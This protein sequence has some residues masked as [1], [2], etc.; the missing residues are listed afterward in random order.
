ML[1]KKHKL[2]VIDDN[3]AL[4]ERRK[5][6]A[7]ASDYAVAVRLHLVE[8]GSFRTLSE[9]SRKDGLSGQRDK[10]SL[11]LSLIRQAQLPKGMIVA[12]GSS[13]G[14]CQNFLEQLSAL[15]LHFVVALTTATK[16]KTQNRRTNT[17]S[18]NA[19]TVEDRLTR[20]R[21]RKIEVQPPDR[22]G[23]SCYEASE[24]GF[25]QLGSLE[26]LRLFTAASGGVIGLK[27]GLFIGATTLVDAPLTQLVDALGWVRWLRPL[28]RRKAREAA[29]SQLKE[30]QPSTISRKQRTDVPSLELVH[31]A[32]ITT[33]IR[34][35]AASAACRH[36][37]QLSPDLRGI[38]AQKRESL[39]V[40]ELF[41]GAGGMGLGFLL[42]ESE[43]TRY[44]ITC[45][46]EV[47]PIYV[48]SL[49][50][51]HNHFAKHQK[52][53]AARRT[54]E[55]VSPLDL[56]TRKAKREVEAAVRASE[57]IDIL[58]GGPPCQGFSN[59][60]RNN[61]RSDNPNNQLVATFL[62]YVELLKPPVILMENVQGILWTPPHGQ[63]SG[64]LSV[65]DFVAARLA[66]A[67]YIVFP[68]LLDAVWYGVPQYRSRF[69]LLGV[70]STLGYSQ[71]DFGAWGPFPH[72]TH[73]P[74]TERE[75]ATVREAIGDLPKIANGAN[76]DKLPYRPSRQGEANSEYLQLMRCGAAESVI[77]DHVA[78]RHAEYV[79]ER[80]K[81]IPM[82]GNWQSVAHMMTNYADVE[83]THSNIYRRLEW[84]KPSITIGH[85]RKSMLIHPEQHRGL[86]L[87]EA[88]RLQSFPDWFRFS[89]NTDNS[90]GGLMHKQQQLANAVCPLVTKA[91]AE[92][93]L[94]L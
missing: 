15:K 1:A 63:S 91:I 27:R 59:A 17:S 67:G 37:S 10:C 40:V 52:I 35:D 32:N 88:S 56:R 65:A 82:G 41:A 71:K 5:H 12:A 85:Y 72:P 30:L 64:S 76:D 73:E 54:P 86:S 93:I 83:R 43:S 79:I 33:A 70:H 38:L 23:T 94:K 81:A 60:N 89:G 28:S 47:D 39:N 49:R 11:A 92:F 9:E 77:S 50:A 3:E 57:G 78:S 24:L 84:D 31:R 7:S 16:I 26:N 6:N 55:A 34:H 44:K 51:N 66:R 61:W 58:I 19:I 87:R 42:A 4:S 14:T 68:K 22:A 2:C 74:G 20:A 21:W 45:A 18:A 46:G 62:E 75:Y 29:A 53:G 8:N 36:T 48:A 69:F 80:Y 13:Y 90:P 25:I